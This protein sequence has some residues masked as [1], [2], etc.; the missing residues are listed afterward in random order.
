M[1]EGSAQAGARPAS[2]SGGDGEEKRCMIVG[3][4]SGGKEE[5]AEEQP[6]AAE[7]V[8]KDKQIRGRAQDG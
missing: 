8:R 1:T 6:E 4:N 5:G 3:G 2:D 7:A